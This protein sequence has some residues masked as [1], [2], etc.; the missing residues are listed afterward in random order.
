MPRGEWQVP[1]GVSPGSWDYFESPSIAG[2]YDAYF[3]DHPLFRLDM[4]WLQ[5]WTAGVRE[6]VDLGCGTGRAAVELARQGL[7]VTAVDLSAQMLEEVRRKAIATGLPVRCVRANLVQLDAL[8]DGSFDL[9]VCLFSTLGMIRTSAAR[10]AAMTHFARVLRPGGT[11]VVHVHNLW[12]ALWLPQGPRRLLSDAVR[13]WR[14]RQWELGDRI[15]PYRGVAQMYLHSFRWSELQ[16]LFRRAGL[17]VIASAA[18]DAHL[19]RQLVGPRWWNDWRASGWIV[20][21]R[22]A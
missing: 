11:L 22:K 16:G 2:D 1:T 12:A 8:A 4:D 3:G 14:D 18:L 5:S 20:T 17:R 13:S 9:G 21:A 15:Y 7:T 19:A 10:Q 6:V